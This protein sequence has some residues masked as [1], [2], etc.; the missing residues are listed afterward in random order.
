[1]GNG[2][3]TGIAAATKSASDEDLKAALAGL[4]ADAR[5]KLAD[6]LAPAAE[7]K[8]EE[9]K[10]EEEKK[11]EPKAEEKKEEEKKE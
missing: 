6:A 1:M 9:P 8:K 10:K 7:E 3:S 2:A 11:E 4:D 5:K